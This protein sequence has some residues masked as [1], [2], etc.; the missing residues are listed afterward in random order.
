MSG[1][2]PVTAAPE[3]KPDTYDTSSRTAQARARHHLNE[4]E[5]FLDG[6]HSWCDHNPD[7]YTDEADAL[8]ATAHAQAA[9]AWLTVLWHS[10]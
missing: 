5:Q 3:G 1:D 9:Q 7:G 10:L 2:T 4:M 6:R 8:W